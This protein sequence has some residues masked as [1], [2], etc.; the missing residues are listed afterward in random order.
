MSNVYGD[1]CKN[2]KPIF[3]SL[4]SCSLVCNWF[5]GIHWTR[6][7]FPI[8][9]VWPVGLVFLTVFWFIGSFIFFYNGTNEHTWSQIKTNHSSQFL[10]FFYVGFMVHIRSSWLSLLTMLSLKLKLYFFWGFAIASNTRWLS[11]R[12]L[13]FF[14]FNV[15]NTLDSY[16]FKNIHLLFELNFI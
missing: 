16:S 1:T 14:S 15:K 10:I 6:L 2:L 7:P 11:R 3:T 5:D 8:E 13:S 12:H 9:L 4:I